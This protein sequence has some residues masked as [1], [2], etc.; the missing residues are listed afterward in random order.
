MYYFCCP[1][2]GS[3]LVREAG[4]LRCK[5][6]HAFDLSAE[7]Y[8]HLLPVNRMHSKAPGDDKKMVASRRLFLE[9]GGYE[10]FAQKLAGLTAESVEGVKK[11]MVLDAGCGEG[12][13][14]EKIAQALPQATVA[15]FDISKLAVKAAAKRYKNCQFA[16][17]SIFDIPAKAA[18]ADCL[19]NVFAP[20][21]EKEFARI[22]KPGGRFIYAVP[23]ARHLY[24]LKEVL[25]DKP[26]ENEVKDTQ[27]EGFSF[28]KRCEVRSDLLLSDPE[29]IEALFSMTPY[30]WNTPKKGIERL[31]MC[32]SLTTEIGFDFL[33]YC[34][35]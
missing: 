8:A 9:S 26:Y 2:C 12:Y 21:V 3:A 20:V 22:L 23:S 27:Y 5:K 14:T 32:D 13:Y 28:E 24:G 1:L 18:S 11:P 30:Y 4:S 17:A 29:M 33:V 19:V 7:G 25:Y 31:K 16:V 15:G 10:P 6:G 34:R 35:K